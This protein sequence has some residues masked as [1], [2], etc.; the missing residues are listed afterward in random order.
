MAPVIEIRNLKKYFSTPRGML[1]AVDDVTFTIEKGKTL[2]VVGE[3][4]CGKSTLG[5]TIIHLHESTSG[6]IFLDGRDITKLKGKALKD[7][8]EEMQIIFQDPYSSLDPR[9][10]IE[11]TIRE[12]LMISGRHKRDEIDAKVEEIM[13]LVGIDARLRQAY[14]HELDGGR[15]QRVGIAR[16]L[17]L[18]PK[19]VVCD[20]P[21]SALD[22]SIQAQVLTLLKKLQ[23]D[24]GL[25]YMFVTHDMSVVRHISDDICV[26]YLGQMVEK[27]PAKE[28]FRNPMHPYTKA[29]LSAIPSVDIHNPNKREILHGEITSPINPPPGCRFAARC[30]HATDAC[31]QPQKQEEIFA[32][33]FVTCCRVHEL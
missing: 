12:P 19:F 21:V 7:V 24:R 20:E 33:H 31:H 22:V 10:T 13:D 17:A 4:G 1:H 6:E 23:Q 27:C 32:G 30:P 16:A 18:E 25:T 8:R 3:S 11:K 28:L 5:R 9:K 14:P 15:R 26:M 29:L 2:G